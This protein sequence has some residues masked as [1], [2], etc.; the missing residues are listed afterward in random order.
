MLSGGIFNYYV[1]VNFAGAFVHLQKGLE[2][3]KHHA[4]VLWGGD[5]CLTKS[6]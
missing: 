1:I 5:L 6:L 4:K 3:I 2:L